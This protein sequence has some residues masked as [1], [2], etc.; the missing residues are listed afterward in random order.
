MLLFGEVD[1]LLF[2]ADSVAILLVEDSED[3]TSLILRAFQKAGVNNPIRVVGDGDAAVSYL[4]GVG[5][6]ADRTEYPMPGLVLL[7]LDLPKRNG[8][9]VLKWIR[10]NRKLTGLS[11]VVLTTSRELKDV[12]RAYSAGANS[13]LVKPLEFANYLGLGHGVKGFWLDVVKK[14]DGGGP[15]NLG[16]NG[17]RE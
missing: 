4:E 15:H 9:E 17:M 2:M 3:D 8:Y 11:V 1:G 14:P 12:S 16:R 10:G 6:Y 5:A 7:D 13:F